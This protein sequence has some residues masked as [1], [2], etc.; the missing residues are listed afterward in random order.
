MAGP[1]PP[2]QPTF[3]GDQVAACER[4]VRR[5]TA[6]Q[7]QVYRA[8]LALLLHVQPALDNGAAGR[9]LGK[10]EHWVRYWSRSWATEG[11]RL[12]DRRGRGR[13]PTFSPLQV[14]R[15]KALA[16]E[17][18]AQR[19]EPLSR[20]STT[21][22][23]RLIGAHPDAPPMSAS[24]I[25]RLLD[26]DALR[27]WR[28]RSWLYPRD[29]QFAAKAGRVLDLYAGWWEGRPL[30]AADCVLSA[31]EKTSI[32][33]RRRCHASMGRSPVKRCGS[34]TSMTGVAR[35]PIWPRGMCGAVV[36]W[37]GAN[38]GPAR[39]RSAGWSSR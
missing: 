29:P 36:H 14:A 37:G 27:P 13:K 18:P 12:A 25:W 1:P 35:W 31:D 38:A 11:F 3:T 2:Y 9:Q 6:P 32:Q 30:T 28:Y 24:T 16:C 23:A 4:L 33:A 34:S 10:H 22:L 5:H 20:Y 26:R 17:L 19:A 21:D 8:R 39:P 15:V 7:A